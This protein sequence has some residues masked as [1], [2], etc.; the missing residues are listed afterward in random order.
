MTRGKNES[1]VILAGSRTYKGRAR[2]RPVTPRSSSEWT[3]TS[4]AGVAVLPNEIRSNADLFRPSPRLAQP[5]VADLTVSLGRL[6][7]PFAKP[8]FDARRLKLLVEQVDLTAEGLTLLVHSPVTV[9]LCHEPPVVDG[10]FV[11]LATE[12]G[13]GG[14][15]PPEGR[16]KPCG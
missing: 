14:S 3:P 16:N 7:P 6:Q 12:G 2:P 13:V 8:P 5:Q 1:F 4:M 15:T 11:E 10:E 9:D